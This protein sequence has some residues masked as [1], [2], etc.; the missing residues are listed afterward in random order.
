MDT[1]TRRCRPDRCLTNHRSSGGIDECRGIGKKEGRGN[2]RHGQP[3]ITSP[4]PHASSIGIASDCR[5]TTSN[6]SSEVSAAP[7][8]TSY[9]PTFDQ[10][11]LFGLATWVQSS[12]TS[13]GGSCR[14]RDYREEEGLDRERK[15]FG[16]VDILDLRPTRNGVGL[17][18]LCLERPSRTYPRILSTTHR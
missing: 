8:T 2:E 11:H 12:K 5:R 17:H 16:A 1:D 15:G 3:D 4:T 14:D 13:T 6:S 10:Y 18:S 9:T 7:Y